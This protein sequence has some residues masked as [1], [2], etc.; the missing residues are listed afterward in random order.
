MPLEKE[1]LDILACPKCKGALTLM[2]AGDGLA[3][4]A[5][6]VVYPVKDDIP[7]MLV[8]HAVPEKDWTGSK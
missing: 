5:C 7:I 4:P 3:C 1:L 8:D 6:G 2:P